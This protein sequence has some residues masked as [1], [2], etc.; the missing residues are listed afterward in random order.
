MKIDELFLTSYYNSK[1]IQNP[2][3]IFLLIKFYSI[4]SVWI[5]GFVLVGAAKIDCD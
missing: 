1:A 4:K 5:L 3:L 2:C